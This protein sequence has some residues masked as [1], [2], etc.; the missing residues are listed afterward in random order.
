MGY[1][2]LELGVLLVILGGLF[3]LMGYIPGLGHLPGDI[4]VQKGNVSCFFP[5]A[6]MI[7]VSVILTLLLNLI[8]RLW[9]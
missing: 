1:L 9:R 6:T 4:R 7:V 3:L 5:L 2:L 8:L